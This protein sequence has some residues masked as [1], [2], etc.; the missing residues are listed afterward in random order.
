[1]K[2]D[3]KQNSGSTSDSDDDF[4]GPTTRKA[5]SDYT[6]VRSSQSEE[7]NSNSMSHALGE[8]QGKKTRKA[9]GTV[10]TAQQKK[11]KGRLKKTKPKKII[12]IN[13]LDLL[14]SETLISTSS[15]AIGMRLPPAAGCFDEQ[16]ASFAGNMIHEEVD[17]PGAPTDTLTIILDIFK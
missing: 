13:G 14:H 5:W 3:A 12:K 1:M 4:L 6:R 11:N 17:I 2:R 8:R 9:K 16:L 15:A 7:E 10:K